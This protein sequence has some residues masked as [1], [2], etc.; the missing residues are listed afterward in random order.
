M[1]AIL[2]TS[3]ENRTLFW[4]V[5]PSDDILKFPWD[6]CSQIL[7]CKLGVVAQVNCDWESQHSTRETD[8]GESV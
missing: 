4:K 2:A 5:L 3:R 1:A 8:T 7:Q 6:F